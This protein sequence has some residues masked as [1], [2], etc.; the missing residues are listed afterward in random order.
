MPLRIAFLTIK[1]RFDLLNVGSV[2]DWSLVACLAVAFASLAM[3][4]YR[5][6]RLAVPI[7]S[8]VPT[9]VLSA[10][11]IFFPDAVFDVLQEP[12]SYL[13]LIAPL[14]IATLGVVLW[15]QSDHSTSTA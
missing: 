2:G 4:Y 11:A 12:S 7:C 10:I 6:G 3:Y 9:G 1:P 8:L 15:D 14:L 5:L 13:I